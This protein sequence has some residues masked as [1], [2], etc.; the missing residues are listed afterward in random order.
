LQGMFSDR[1]LPAEDVAI[2]ERLQKASVYF[3]E[4]FASG[5]GEVVA[6]FAVET[7]NK[8]IRKKAKDLCKWLQ[9]ETA[10]KLAAVRCCQ[11]GFSSAGYLK[12]ISSAEI[13]SK[14][15]REKKL[16][17]IYL[18]ADVGHPDLFQVL[19]EWR[20]RTAKEENVPH[21][22]VMHQK[23]LVQIAVNLPD[24]IPTLAKLKG[25]GK[26][27]AE[28]YGEELVALVTTYRAANDIQEVFLPESPKTEAETPKKPGEPKAEKGPK[29]PT[30]LLTLELF[31]QG[32][33]VA[34]ISER[35][36]FACTTIES[37]LAQCLEMGEIT[38]DRLISS[39]KQHSLEEIVHSR[40]QQKL[41]EI[42]EVV[43]D[44]YSYGEIKYVLA[45]LRYQAGEH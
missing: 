41:S 35:R 19:K 16:T 21:Y 27:L 22:Q 6:S 33:T 36:G 37:H 5:I 40:R 29:V 7:D 1:M 24:N 10:V 20:S 11:S 4:K 39:E 3:Q 17:P 18:E 14:P 9:E 15:K 12:A 23:T 38:V 26:K 44:A 8:E 31:N 43:G 28:R 30:R 42:K 13:D 2:G 34:Q 45:H 32:L 25:I